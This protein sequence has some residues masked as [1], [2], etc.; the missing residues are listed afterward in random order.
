MA[1]ETRCNY[2]GIARD[3]AVQTVHVGMPLSPMDVIRLY[4]IEHGAYNTPC[5]LAVFN[6]FNVVSR[7]D[8]TLL[9]TVKAAAPG[10]HRGKQCIVICCLHLLQ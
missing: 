2:L 10:S 9:Q 3:R 4:S 8:S 5:Y 7:L 1:H 6:N